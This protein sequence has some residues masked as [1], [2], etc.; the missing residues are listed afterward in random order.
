[1]ALSLNPLSGVV[2]RAGITKVTGVID[3]TG[4]V[5]AAFGQYMVGMLSDRWTAFQKAGPVL[6]DCCLL[7]VYGRLEMRSRAFRASLG[8]VKVSKASRQ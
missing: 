2:R 7:Q 8:S 6:G 5:G 1:M 4:A 3:G